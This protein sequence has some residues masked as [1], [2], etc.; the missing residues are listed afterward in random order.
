MIIGTVSES[1]SAVRQAPR[2][3]TLRLV[4]VQTPRGP[5]TA[6]DLTGA[7]IGDRVVLLTGYAAAKLD[8]DAPADA[9]VV[10]VLRENQK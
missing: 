9:A 1:L 4:T 10:A 2:L 3:G 8:M 5:V 7:G 6:A